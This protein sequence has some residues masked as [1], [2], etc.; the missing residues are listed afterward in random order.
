[1]NQT[2]VKTQQPFHVMTK[3][4]GPICNLDCEYCFYLKKEDLYPETK[5]FRMT[6]EVLE[7]YVRGY[8]EA[9]PTNEVV[10]AFQGGEPTLM[11]LRFFEKVV[12]Y[13]KQYKRR[14]MTIQ[15]TLQTNGTLLN[16]DWATFLKKHKFLVGISL[17][18]PPNLHDKYR[19]DKQGRPSHQQVVD[20]IRCLQA[21]Q[22]DYNILCVV[23]ECNAQ[24]PVEVYNYIKSL[25]VEYMQFIPIVEHFGDGDQVS[26]RSV[27]AKQYGQFL[28]AIFD[29][30]VQKDIGKIF[31]QIFDIAL[32]AW[33]GYN[34]SL[35]IFN[36]TCGSA[37]ALEHNGDLYSCDHYVEPEYLVGNI[38]NQTMQELIESDFQIKFGNDKKDTLPQYCLDCEVKFMCNGGCPKNRFIKTPDGEDGLNY[39]CQGYRHFFNHIDQPMKLMAAAL[40]RGQPAASIMAV[41][42]KRRAGKNQSTKRP[43]RKRRRQ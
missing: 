6:D 12:A 17:D 35:C 27:G 33:L 5:S 21:H 13:Q 2:K 39:L 29:E 20:G 16:D 25:D 41:M 15:N 8:I 18:G 19:F 14:G 32:E 37:L 34:P 42:Q 3:P 10:F 40:E 7:N 24:K 26:P 4:I 38:N 36:E 1:M 28:S 43:R 22:V 11:G 31:V 23:N 30:W 9:Q